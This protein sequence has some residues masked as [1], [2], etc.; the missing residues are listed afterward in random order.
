MWEKIHDFLKR[1]VLHKTRDIAIDPVGP[2][3]GGTA[4]GFP[5]L[6]VILA[7]LVT[8]GL[9]FAIIMIVKISKK[10]KQAQTE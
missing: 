1:E 10:K 6:P 8:G 7:V 9:V 2:A 4:I 5:F 3:I